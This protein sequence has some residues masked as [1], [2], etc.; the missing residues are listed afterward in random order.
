[1][2]R[3]SGGIIGAG[4]LGVLGSLFWTCA[5]SAQASV[6]V[7][8]HYELYAAGLHVA[9]VDTGY[10]LG[11]QTYQMHLAYHT[12]GLVSL[13]RR[14]NNDSV[15][16]GTWRGDFAVPQRFLAVGA[17]RGDP[18]YADIDFSSGMPVVR[19]LVPDDANQRQPVPPALENGSVDTLSAMADLMR[20]VARTGACNLSLRTYDGHRVLRFDARTMGQ[21]MLGPYRGSEFTGPALR[22]DFTATP[23]AGV[24]IDDDPDGHV[25]RGSVWLASP[26]PAAT[27]MPVRMAL[28]TRWFGEAVMYLMDV[29]PFPTR[30]VARRR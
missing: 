27:S 5:A 4:L 15:V 8:S 3:R 23:I 24:K 21:E 11:P 25:F 16:S 6:S 7:Q 30:M 13:F 26:I 20:M 17:W 28:E 18:R 14:G 29:E 19:R 22:C 12:T 1:M 9:D 10:A 2:Q